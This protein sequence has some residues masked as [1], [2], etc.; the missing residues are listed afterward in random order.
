MKG[1]R[2]VYRNR[3]NII[4]LI[5]NKGKNQGNDRK[6]NEIAAVYAV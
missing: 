2:K 3:E 5:K 1:E 4:K 6:M